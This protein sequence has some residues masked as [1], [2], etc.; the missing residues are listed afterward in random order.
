[1]K[2]K[3]N[4]FG[5]LAVLNKPHLPHATAIFVSTVTVRILCEKMTCTTAAFTTKC[6]GHH[7][8]YH[9]I[10]NHGGQHN[11]E[12]VAS[13]VKKVIKTTGHPC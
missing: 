9:Y 1:M 4:W 12:A 5:S 13:A 7:H 8:Y 6:H 10:G 3:K 2:K 11:K